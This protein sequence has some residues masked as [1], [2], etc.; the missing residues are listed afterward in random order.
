MEIPLAKKMSLIDSSGIRK[1]FNLASRMKDPVNL[2]IGQPDFDAPEEL[3]ESAIRAIR[4]GKNKYTLTQGLPELNEKLLGKYHEHYPARKPES[5]M[6]TSGVSGAILLAFM[7][8]IDP[9]DE[10]LIPDPYFVMY[11][12]LVNLL[13]GVPVT[14]DIYPDFRI[15]EK[16]LNRALSKKSKIII[17]NS[18]NNPTGMVHTPEEIRLVVDFAREKGLFLISDEIYDTYVYNDQFTSVLDFTDEALVLNG[19]SKNFSATGWRMGFAMGPSRLIQEMIK[20]QQYTF[21]CAPSPFQYA[22]LENLNFDFTKVRQ[23]YKTKRDTLYNMLKDR[24]RVVKPEGAFYMFPEAPGGS[25]SAFVEKAIEKQL[26]IIPGNVFSEKDT[27]F[28]VSFAAPSETLKKGGEIL[29]SLA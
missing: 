24:F 7:A 28:R 12:H 17:L 9:G 14:Y 26:L 2:S 8:L 4:Q 10:V 23:D 27:H 11:K 5:I 1:V 3:K 15:T 13:G 6:I 25:A 22:V 21:V 16:A 29:L 18:P 20:L 19:F